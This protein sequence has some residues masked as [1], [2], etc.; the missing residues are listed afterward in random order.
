MVTELHGKHYYIQMNSYTEALL[1]EEFISNLEALKEEFWT[2]TKKNNKW[3]LFSDA[4][5]GEFRGKKYS[6]WE[7]VKR[8]YYKIK[9]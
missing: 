4:K 7:Q 8:F 5:C 9:S 2:V 3:I 1:V 6:A